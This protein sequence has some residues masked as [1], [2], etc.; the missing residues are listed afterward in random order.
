[1]PTV[2]APAERFGDGEFEVERGRLSVR[3]CRRYCALEAACASGGYLVLD[4]QKKKKRSVIR[5][6]GFV[7][8]GE[9]AGRTRLFFSVM[10]VRRAEPWPWV[11]KG[12]KVGVGRRAGRK[13]APLGRKDIVGVENSET[14]ETRDSSK[15]LGMMALPRLLLRTRLRFDNFPG[16]QL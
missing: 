11:S 6:M 15:G 14:N 4:L 12:S 1:V 7:S 8:F 3:G 10:S 13:N 16:R 9:R 5:F 2:A